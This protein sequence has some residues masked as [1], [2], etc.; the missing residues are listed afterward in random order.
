MKLH[1]VQMPEDK[2]VGGRLILEAPVGLAVSSGHWAAFIRKPL[3]HGTVNDASMAG[4]QIRVE[5]ELQPGTR[6][7]LWIEVQTGARFEVLRL[8]GDVVRCESRGIR[9]FYLVGIQL[10]N[11]QASALRAWEDV[12]ADE[13]RQHTGPA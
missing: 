2:R 8:A 10:R 6:M 1:L 4:L 5:Q 12:M 13:I 7:L 11:R 3:F 9:G